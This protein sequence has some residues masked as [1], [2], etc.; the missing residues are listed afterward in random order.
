MERGDE[1]AGEH[2]AGTLRARR[3]AWSRVPV[4]A[5]SEDEEA[6]HLVGTGRPGGIRVRLTARDDGPCA[7]WAEERA[8][9]RRDVVGRRRLRRERLEL[10]RVGGDPRRERDES[11]PQGARDGGLRVEADVRIAEGR[12]DDHPERRAASE[13]RREPGGDRLDL[14]RRDEVARDDGADLVGDAEGVEVGERPGEPLSRHRY[15][16][17]ARVVRQV[18]EQHGGD[19]G[20][21]ESRV[22]QDR[23]DAVRPD[24]AVHELRAD[25]EHVDGPPVELPAVAC[26]GAS[27]VL[28]LVHTPSLI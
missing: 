6:R 3:D 16:V 19:P 18:A 8:R 9:S 27:H 15:G 24:R 21:D 25:D 26:R 10:E 14:L 2:V 17:H 11:G 1:R 7:A 20:D 22:R 12:I 5:V 4:V 23:D 28:R 13:Q